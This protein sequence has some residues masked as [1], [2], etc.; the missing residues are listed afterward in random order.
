MTGVVF[1]DGTRSVLFFGRHGLGPF[2]YGTGEKCHDPYDGSQG[3]HG[4]PYAY[5]VW[6][7]DAVDLAAAKNGEKQPWDIKPYAVWNLDLPFASG[8]GHLNGAAYDPVTGQIF[9]SQAFGDGTKP[10]IHVFTV[11]STASVPPPPPVVDSP[12]ETSRLIP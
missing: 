11:G 4:Y 6:A 9:V 12:Q 2:C 8:S 5:R 7:Y 10:L 1:P 3:T